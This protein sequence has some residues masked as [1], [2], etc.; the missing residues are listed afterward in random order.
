MGG[1]A[2][3]SGESPLYTPRMPPAVYEYVIKDCQAKLRDLFVAI[4]SPI[5]GPAK[6]DYGDVDVFVVWDKKSIFPSPLVDNLVSSLAPSTH[7]PLEAAVHLLG[8]E[9]YVKE[10]AHTIISA[11]P[12]PED[13]PQGAE[14][15][16]VKPHQDTKTPR[17]IQVDLHLCESLER[18][19]WMLFKQAHGDLWN[20]LGSTIRPYG[21]TMDGMG[22][23]VRIP[24]IESLNKKQ[25][26]V[27]LTAEPA[28]ILNFLGLKHGGKEWEEPFASVDELFEYAATCRLFW[29]RPEKDE[30]NA[31]AEG[32]DVDKNKFKSND[33]RRMNYRPIFKKWVDEFLPACREAG[34][35][36]TQTATRDSV[37]EEA[38]RFFPGTQ[39][40]YEARLLE[41]RKERQRQT[42]WKGVI[43]A[44]IP[45][46]IEGETVM[47]GNGHWRGVLATALKK[48]IME[49]DYSLDVRP[50]TPLRDANGMY[51]EERVK[52]FVV[53]NWRDIGRAAWEAHQQRC[54]DRMV[55]KETK[56]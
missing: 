15:E 4:A 25:A 9:R 20:I 53:D 45:E 16:E 14:N 32:G 39:R 54:A 33:R 8:A 11:I 44:S 51:Y 43:K 34:R 6:K 2:F 41:W 22:L 3:S 42:L 47:L 26:K 52:H 36:T 18:L 1:L 23:Y 24:E 21:L 12:W 46:P 35:F 49:D 19:Q 31:A 30:N 7:D 48:I 27:L 17:Y 50:A 40:A 56:H 38:F 37:R 5:Q 55:K 29:V 10:Q 28:Q 13:L